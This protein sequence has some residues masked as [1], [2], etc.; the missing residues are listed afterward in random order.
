MLHGPTNSL[1]KSDNT[2]N[3][4]SYWTNSERI[5]SLLYSIFTLDLPVY[6]SVLGRWCILVFKLCRPNFCGYKALS[7]VLRT[8]CTLWDTVTSKWRILY[9]ST[10]YVSF[11]YVYQVLYSTYR[12]EDYIITLSRAIFFFLF[13]GF[14][15]DVHVILWRNPQRLKNSRKTF[16]KLTECTWTL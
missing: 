10:I 9:R 12:R 4:R 1:L 6:N 15:G 16:Q 3:E 7:D 13:C 8:A 5:I 14:E 11:V 2:M